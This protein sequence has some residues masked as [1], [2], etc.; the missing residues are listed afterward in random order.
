MSAE[1]RQD[2]YHHGNLREAL[3][4]EGVKSLQRNGVKSLSLRRLARRCGVS[5]AAPYAHF[6]N[7]EALIDAMEE[8]VMSELTAELERTAATNTG[9][10]NLLLELGVSYVL[11]FFENP[12]Y[13]TALFSR[14]RRMAAIFARLPD[15]G[16]I[17]DGQAAN[18]AFAF[19]EKLVAPKLRSLGL[20]E[21]K[22]HTLLIASWAFV[23]GLSS[24]VCAKEI[25]DSLR[26]EGQVANRIRDILSSQR[27]TLPYRHTPVNISG[28]IID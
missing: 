14:N 12:A 24:I 17:E 23:H 15:S 10:G 2:T 27:P 22:A 16:N 13:F 1:K 20:T 7:K 4:Q 6:K 25:N 21:E 5:P 19:L 26:A 18:P 9:E 11:F 3:I 8:H 28:D